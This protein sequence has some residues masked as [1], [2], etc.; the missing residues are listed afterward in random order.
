ME[1][2][3]NEPH[4]IRLSCHIPPELPARLGEVL[5]IIRCGNTGIQLQ[6]PVR[7]F[8]KQTNKQHLLGKTVKAAAPA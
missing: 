1:G 4:L 7:L 6:Q 8:K 3:K 2:E 5:V